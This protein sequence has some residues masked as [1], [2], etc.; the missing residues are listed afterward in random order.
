[1]PHLNVVAHGAEAAITAA[2]NHLQALWG[3][4]GEW[5]P[6]SAFSGHKSL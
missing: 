2:L 3:L 4:K 1:V 6:L 5:K